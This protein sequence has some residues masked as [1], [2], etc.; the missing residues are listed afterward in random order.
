MCFGVA[1]TAASA[2]WTLARSR[3]KIQSLP[4]PAG[5]SLASNH[6]SSSI[7]ESCVCHLFSVKESSVS[8]VT[9]AACASLGM[10]SA[11]HRQKRDKENEWGWD[12]LANLTRIPET[13]RK[14][15]HNSDW[16]RRPR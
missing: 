16:D 8:A 4:S 1:F 13:Q 9:C 6:P 5:F 12:E 10:T 3:T 14:E 2:L 15:Y 7:Q 11:W